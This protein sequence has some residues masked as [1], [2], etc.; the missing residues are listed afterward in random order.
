VAAGMT[1]TTHFIRFGVFPANSMQEILESRTRWETQENFLHDTF[2]CRGG[3]IF[4]YIYISMVGGIYIYIEVVKFS[5]IY[6]NFQIYLATERFSSFHMGFQGVESSW[7]QNPSCGQVPIRWNL[8][9]GGF[10]A[11]LLKTDMIRKGWKAF[12]VKCKKI[13]SMHFLACTSF[14]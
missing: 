2:S 7:N 13:E 10:H 12:T 6:I 14:H 5:D 9:I 1:G 4:R 8:P 3:E 11:L